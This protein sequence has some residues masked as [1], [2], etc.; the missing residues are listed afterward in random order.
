MEIQHEVICFNSVTD[1]ESLLVLYFNTLNRII[2]QFPVKLK[3]IRSSFI[4]I[5]FARGFVGRILNFWILCIGSK[6]PERRALP[7]PRTSI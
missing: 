1:C 7:N 5:V 4:M 2:I 6:L 3:I